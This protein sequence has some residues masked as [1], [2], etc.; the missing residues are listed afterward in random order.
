[1][2]IYGKFIMEDT[3]I[4]F[5]RNDVDATVTYTVKDI[6]TQKTET[7]TVPAIAFHKALAIAIHNDGMPDYK[8]DYEDAESVQPV[9]KLLR[10]IP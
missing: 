2:A 8:V 5:R 3:A 9:N 7:L 10:W 6:P 1:M 4:T